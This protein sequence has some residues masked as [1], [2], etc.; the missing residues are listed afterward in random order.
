MYFYY[1]FA[2]IHFTC[3]LYNEIKEVSQTQDTFTFSSLLT[4]SIRYPLP[5]QGRPR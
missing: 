3:T 1:L 4:L 5:P 2:Y